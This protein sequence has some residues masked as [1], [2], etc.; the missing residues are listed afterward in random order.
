M[1]VNILSKLL[2]F[3]FVL[4]LSAPLLRAQNETADQIRFNASL[5]AYVDELMTD[6]GTDAIR[7][8][9]FLVKQIRML[10]EE[11]KSR[12]GSVPNIHKNY[13]DRLENRLSEVRELKSRLSGTSSFQLNNFIVDIEKEIDHTIKAGIVDFQKQKVIEEAVQLLYVAEEAIKLD[14]NASVEE[15]PMFSE[16]FKT[17]KRDFINSFGKKAILTPEQ[18]K[19]VANATIFDVYE[20]WRYNNRLEFQKRWTDVEIIKNRLVKNGTDEER[21]RMFNRELV[22]AS[23][24]FNYGFYDLAERMFGEIATRYK[25]IGM[26]DDC[27]YYKGESNYT[28]GRYNQAETD[29]KALLLQYPSSSFIP[30]AYTRLMYISFHFNKYDETINYLDRMQAIVSSSDPALEEARFLGM[31]SGLKSGRYDQTVSLGFEIPETSR[32]YREARFAMAEAYA[33]AGNYEEATNIFN[34]LLQAKIFDLNFR[35]TIFLKLGYLNYELG[36]YNSAIKNFDQIPGSFPNYDRVLIGYGWA[37]Y[38]N[39][40][41]KE[42][43]EDRDFTLAKKNL[44]LLIDL[45]YGSDYYLEAKTLVGYIYQLEENTRKAIENFTYAYESKETKQLSDDMNVERDNLLKSYQA[46]SGLEEKALEAN[47]VSAFSRAYATK[48]KI[49][50]PLN[51]LTMVDLSASGVAVRNEVGRLNKQLIELDRLKTIAEQ[52][53]DKKSIDRI[54][55]MQLKIYRAV[56]MMSEPEKSEFGI[57]Y[58]DEHPFARKES[59]IEHDNASIQKM[60]EEVSQQKMEVDTRLAQLDV[61]IE[62]AKARRDYKKV[63]NLEISKDRFQDLKKNLDLMETRA[64]T[65]DIRTSNINVDEWSD[66]GAFGVANVNFAVKQMKQEEITHLLDQVN[67]INQFLEKRKENIEHKIDQINQEITVMTRRVKEQERR[68]EREEMKRRFEESYFDTHDSELNYKQDTTS[69]PKLN[70]Q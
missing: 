56:N 53:N 41:N 29:F 38:K 25:L 62:N 48:K 63:I 70:E 8:E 19:Q 4:F 33:G 10:N 18:A 35:S 46:A 30:A 43:P 68:R 21:K 34:S 13:F 50:G 52:R 3:L 66:Y 11:I 27:L 16:E 17:T 67:Q 5:K 6:F 31:I 36:D 32:Y 22:Q 14:P 47:N 24:M 55:E 20:A 49:R 1:K 39:E 60:R 12:V 26:L 64:Y 59:M 15:D 37:Y 61:D 58:F 23:E 28:L 45:F 54:E 51:E 40:L 7:H 44:E 57:N 65:F 42:R 69:P 2:A 9:R